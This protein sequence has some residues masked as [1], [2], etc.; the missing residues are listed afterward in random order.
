M[1]TTWKKLTAGVYKNGAY[2]VELVNGEWYVSYK[3]VTF[4][5]AR[6]AKQAKA[7]AEAAFTAE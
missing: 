3:H 7:M 6:T 1:K 5:V 4:E 2:M